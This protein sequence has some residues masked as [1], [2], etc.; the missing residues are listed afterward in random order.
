MVEMFFV[1]FFF[2]STSASLP[3]SLWC[4]ATLHCTPTV[5]GLWGAKHHTLLLVLFAGAAS[6]EIEVPLPPAEGHRSKVSLAVGGD[7]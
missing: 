1:L 7:K 4:S 3:S 2:L 5:R 6:L